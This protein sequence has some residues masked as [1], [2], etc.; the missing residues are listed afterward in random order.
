MLFVVMISSL[1]KIRISSSKMFSSP[2]RVPYVK[3]RCT[4]DAGSIVHRS[5][6]LLFSGLYNFMSNFVS[7]SEIPIALHNVYAI[8]GVSF[9]DHLIKLPDNKWVHIGSV[10]LQ[11][12]Y[13]TIMLDTSRKTIMTAN[14]RADN[15][16]IQGVI[17]ALNEWK[18]LYGTPLPLLEHDNLVTITCFGTY[19]W[20][21]NYCN[22]HGSCGHQNNRLRPCI[23]TKIA[24]IVDSIHQCSTR[25]GTAPVIRIT[26]RNYKVCPKYDRFESNRTDTI[27]ALMHG[28]ARREKHQR[29]VYVSL[30]G[31]ET[32]IK[33]ENGFYKTCTPRGPVYRHVRERLLR[34]MHSEIIMFDRFSIAQYANVAMSPLLSREKMTATIISTMKFIID[35]SESITILI[36]DDGETPLLEIPGITYVI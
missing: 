11:C 7:H 17:L 18:L 20:Y 33:E 26:M 9:D 12:T 3:I 10:W 13:R 31:I 23:M 2:K 16:T 36:V 30:A 8:R 32:M 29:I 25:C 35:Y 24:H 21:W 6:R 28:M 34:L 22:N 4:Y 14:I 1:K 5:S 19:D 15:D 27:K